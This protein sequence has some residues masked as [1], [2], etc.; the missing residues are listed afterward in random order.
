MHM[1]STVA[2]KSVKSDFI[3]HDSF[4]LILLEYVFL[5]E[6]WEFFLEHGSAFNIKTCRR[7]YQRIYY[8]LLTIKL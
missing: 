5:Q 7:I 6:P 2:M 8:K 1:F 4:F 3:A